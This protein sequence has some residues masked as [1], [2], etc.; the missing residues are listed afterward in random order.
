MEFFWSVFFC[1]QPEYRKIRTRKYSTF[2]HSSC[3]EYYKWNLETIPNLLKLSEIFGNMILREKCPC[4]ELFWSVFSRIQTEYGEIRNI[5]PYSV[6][7]RENT[8][9]NNS[10]Y[11]HF[12]RSVT[13]NS[14][15]LKYLTIIPHK[16]LPFFILRDLKII[17]IPSAFVILVDV[18]YL[19]HN[20]T[21]V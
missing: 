20:F 2:W 16:Q 6:Q 1:N 11:G 7:M 21:L 13:F 4:L 10:E 8:D 5:S 17:M 15:S 19:K 9:Q 14:D 3:S 18:I 12:L